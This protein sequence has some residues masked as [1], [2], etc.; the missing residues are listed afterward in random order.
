MM[1]E[2]IENGAELTEEAKS[3]GLVITLYAIT[4]LD[5][6]GLALIS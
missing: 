5:T 4:N 6:K 2:C 3:F 1:N